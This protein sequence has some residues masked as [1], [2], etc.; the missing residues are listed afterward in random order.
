MKFEMK[1]IVGACPALLETLLLGVS[2]NLLDLVTRLGESV[3]SDAEHGWKMMGK[4]TCQ[5]ANLRIVQM[6]LDVDQQN[7]ALVSKE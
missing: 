5:P 1:T 2:L 4:E 6:K 7:T 3:D